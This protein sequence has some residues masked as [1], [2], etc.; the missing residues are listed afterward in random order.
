M[1]FKAGKSPKDAAD[2]VGNKLLEIAGDRTR[3]SL[4]AV[5]YAVGGNADFY[6]PVDTNELMNSRSVRVRKTESGWKAVISYGTSYAAALHGTATYSPL[7]KPVNPLEREWRQRSA[8]NYVGNGTGGYNP[9]A[10][11]GW[12][13]RGVEDTDINGILKEKMKL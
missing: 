2:N 9:S 12:I 6:V 13:F 5:A 1:P 10:K 7:W 4:A 8:K 3:A 11:P